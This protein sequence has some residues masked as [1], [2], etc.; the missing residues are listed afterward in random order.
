MKSKK[1]KRATKTYLNYL[2]SYE[3][4]LEKRIKKK[5]LT[6]TVSGVSGSG[7]TTIAKAIARTLGLKLVS[8]GDIFRFIAKKR[9]VRIERFSRIR[10]KKVDYDID[11]E[12]LKR[13]MKGG[14]LIVGRLSGW[15]AGDWADA[16]IYVSCN[17]KVRAARIAGRERISRN[18]AMRKMKQR[19][20]GDTKKYK[21]LYGIN[22]YDRSIYDI[23]INNSRL[24][25]AQAKS[26][27]V[28][29]VRKFLKKRGKK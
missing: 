23:V 10:E 7:K 9:G 25:Y 20:R 15:V 13:A 4:R 3:K 26:L 8:A 11:R 17:Q 1:G 21:R 12:T 6:I 16:K 24:T 28:R 2:A 19:D 18:A 5:G 27:P 14:H 22:Q 29:R